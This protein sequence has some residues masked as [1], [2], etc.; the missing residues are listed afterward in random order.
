M[1]IDPRELAKVTKEEL[2]E[3]RRDD[4]LGLLSRIDAALKA[5]TKE[6]LADEITPEE[7]QQL[8]DEKKAAGATSCEVVTENNKRFLVCQWPPL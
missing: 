7:I 8:I 6:E 1:G 4:L 5:K 2:I 3:L